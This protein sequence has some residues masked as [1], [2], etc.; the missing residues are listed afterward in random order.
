MDCVINQLERKEQV[1]ALLKR[2]PFSRAPALT[3]PTCP[4]HI[5]PA[6]PRP[7]ICAQP[8]A[9]HQLH[10]IDLAG[11]G[12]RALCVPELHVALRAC[13][14]HAALLAPPA[15]AERPERQRPHQ[16]GS[17][18][19]ATNVRGARR[20]GQVW[21]CGGGGAVFLP[22]LKGLSDNNLINVAA[23]M[24]HQT[25]EVRRVDAKCGDAE[26]VDVAAQRGK[27]RLCSHTAQRPTPHL[28]PPLRYSFSYSSA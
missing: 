3:T 24:P 9:P 20:G 10:P 4:L 18:H 8:T 5:Q 7:T 23:N 27:H 13:R 26:C 11:V 19:A 22:M 6:V 1:S 21:R 28:V 12:A 14:A 25:F 16:G 2:R 17:K 15:N